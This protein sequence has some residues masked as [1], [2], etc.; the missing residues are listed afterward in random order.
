M[1][2]KPMVTVPV[3][4]EVS[5]SSSLAGCTVGIRQTLSFEAL[6]LCGIFK[7]L[8]SNYFVLHT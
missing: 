3:H 6:R 4:P 8:V 7:S 1:E 5:L 2:F